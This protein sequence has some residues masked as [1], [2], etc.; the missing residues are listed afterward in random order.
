M[1]GAQVPE[2]PCQVS[3]CTLTS[4]LGQFGTICGAQLAAVIGHSVIE[5]GSCRGG[6][7]ANG[8]RLSFLQELTESRAA[9]RLTIA[10]AE[11]QL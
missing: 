7:F 6:S 4:V 5:L 10:S 8:S 3:F 1:D 9:N 11:R 2:P